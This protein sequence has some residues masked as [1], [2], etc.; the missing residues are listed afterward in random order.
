MISFALCNRFMY[1]FLHMKHRFLVSPSALPCPGTVLRSSSFLLNTSSWEG[2]GGVGGR[3]R[4]GEKGR[5]SKEGR[6][7]TGG[8]GM[9]KG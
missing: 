6:E 5:I 8:G 9:E 2:E 4:E 1:R 3:E 7:G